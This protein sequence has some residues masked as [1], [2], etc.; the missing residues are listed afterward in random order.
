MQ[1][2]ALPLGFYFWVGKERRGREGLEAWALGQAGR[3]GAEARAPSTAPH[4]RALP[5]KYR[6]LLKEPGGR[7]PWAALSR[8]WSP[9]L[10]AACPGENPSGQWDQIVRA[11]RLSKP[12]CEL[13]G[14]GLGF[15]P[16]GK[17]LHLS[18]ECVPKLS[19]PCLWSWGSSGKE[20][21][22]PTSGSVI[23]LKL[24]LGKRGSVEPR[25]HPLPPLTP[26]LGHSQVLGQTEGRRRW[27]AG[28]GW[29]SPGSLAVGPGRSS[30]HLAQLDLLPGLRG[31]K[32][33]RVQ[34]AGHS[35]GP[36]ND[37]TDLKVGG[38]VRGQ[39]GREQWPDLPKS[40]DEELSKY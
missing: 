11:A 10:Q 21:G 27:G 22:A 24:N 35:E 12:G 1:A 6:T 17:G 20:R 19:W 33:T 7:C 38:M 34:N 31:C 30:M 26:T 5:G 28:Q 36:T 39:W 13:I 14:M 29:W 3:D 16:T 2:A 37:G 9:G 4:F 8:T 18:Q 25:S 23:Y 15:P 32:D 40:Q